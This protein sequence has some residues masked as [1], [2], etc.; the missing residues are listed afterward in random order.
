MRF[1]ILSIFGALALFCSLTS[2]NAVTIYG[3][4]E[5]GGGPSSL[6]TIDPSTG[7]ATLVGAIGYDRV[8]ALDFDPSTGIL[9]GI[10]SNTPNT[11]SLIT[12]D[13]T[14][15]LGTTVGNTVGNFQDIN[16]RSDGTLFGFAG[17]AL[18]TLNLT[19]GSATLVGS[20][21]SGIGTGNG[22][23]FDPMDTLY[24]INGDTISTLDQSDASETVTGTVNYPVDLVNP[25][26]N[27]MDYDLTTGT[28]YASV[29]HSVPG[30]RPGSLTGANFIAEIDLA[31]GDVSNAR[32]TISGLD[33]LAVLPEQQ[34]PPTNGVPESMSTLWLGLVLIGLF[35]CRRFRR[36]R[37]C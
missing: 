18:Y 33:G 30:D 8:G 4:A 3:S 14:T 37:F 20:I 13:T 19:D 1:I 7:A 9:Y 10:G 29:I 2:A 34:V 16:F 12:I 36:A 27:A 26:T 31:T 6:Y 28:L 23:A 25:R 24:R 32:L 11:F 22:L 17:G 35:A 15:G 5:I 21:S